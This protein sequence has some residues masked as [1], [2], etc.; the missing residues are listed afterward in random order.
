MFETFNVYLKASIDTKS[1]AITRVFIHGFVEPPKAAEM[2]EVVLYWIGGPS[3]DEAT[4]LLRQEI[5]KPH[6]AWIRPIL[7]D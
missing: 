4:R 6:W 5:E 2:P 7:D 3:L 1:R